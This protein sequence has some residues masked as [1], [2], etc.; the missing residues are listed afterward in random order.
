LYNAFGE[1]TLQNLVAKL[2]YMTL[3]VK[4]SALVS[5]S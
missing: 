2:M 5:T 1:I 4:L 3:T